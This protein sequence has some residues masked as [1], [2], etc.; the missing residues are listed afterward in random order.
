[1][2][3]TST[4]DPVQ[5]DAFYKDARDRL[6]VQTYA[7]TGD[8]PAARAAV[9]DSFIVAWHHWRKVSRLD[10][11]ETSVRPHAW[12]H[13]Q[14]RR[15]ARVW[16]RDKSLDPEVRATLESLGKLS[17]S[18]RKVLLLTLLSTGSL[19]DIAREVGLPR[20]EAER[21]LQSAT[22]RFA[23]HRDIASADVRAAL[24]PL[25]T[26]LTDP[27]WP[28]AT[29]IRRAGAARRRTH[30]TLGVVGTVA[31]LVVSGALVTQGGDLRP[32][33]A[34]PDT[35]RPVVAPS[36]VA[37]PPASLSPDDL[38]T[39]DQVTRLDR[40]QR[41]SEGQTSDNTA[42]TGLAVPCRQARYADP[43]GGQTL[44]RRF[45][46]VA[47]KREPSMSAVQISELSATEPAARTT[48]ETAV[49]WYA[50][51]LDRRMQLVDTH[52]VVRVG[53]E[54]ALFTLRS[55]KSPVSTLVVGVARTGLVTT[56]T[57]SRGR[58]TGPVRTAAP[59]AL[60][61][62]ATNALCGAPGA[63]TCAGPPR[64]SEVAPYPVGEAPGM[65]SEVDLP[66]VTRVEKPWVGTQVRKA[67]VNYAASGCAR[68]NFN[69]DII[70]N[71][72]TR[73]FVIPNA[74]LPAEF[75]LTETV[76][77]MPDQAAGDWLERVRQQ[78]GV[79]AD[80]RLGTTVERVLTRSGADADITVWH[81]TTEISDSRS[82]RYLMAVVR[83]GT[84]VSQLGFI[85]AEGVTMRPGAFIDLAERA[86]VRLD[87]MPRPERAKGGR[88]SSGRN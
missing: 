21:Q 11:P 82:V 43:G 2:P 13:A 24:G 53:D 46:T 6:L 28:R 27:H 15:T 39:A 8:L 18:Q 47:S 33:L 34:D 80:K 58:G 45:D 76:G 83:N 23:V 30:T 44:M 29:I 69:A 32:A 41:W 60:L 59:A 20:D 9:R 22:A 49:G 7:L 66:P 64:L 38:L 86:Q 73:S 36:P 14:R 74:K 31:A 37:A 16:H 65:L 81:L 87:R 88:G 55:W 10:D 50:G 61:A 42:G 78:I 5:F 12:A 85:P 57:L 70:S 1:M 52:R 35:S 71:A 77:T 56:T 68:A 26:H 17:V 54:A 3:F 40:N 79:C 25:H 62:A 75:G 19:S 48:F 4:R 67:T 72:L 84:A 51:C 63:A